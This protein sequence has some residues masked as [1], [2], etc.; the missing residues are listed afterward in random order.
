MYI[1]QMVFA[2]MEKGA[3]QQL[4]GDQEIDT[5][6]YEISHGNVVNSM[7]KTVYNILLTLYGDTW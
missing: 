1:E 7:V 6:S 5:S 2:T 3:A 4:K